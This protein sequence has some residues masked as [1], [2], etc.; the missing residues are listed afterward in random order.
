VIDSIDGV[1]NW[2]AA[3]VGDLKNCHEPTIIFGL[4]TENN[5]HD[6]TRDIT[7]TLQLSFPKE[8]SGQAVVIHLSAM[9]AFNEASFPKVLKQLL[10][11]PRLVPVG[12][13]LWYDTK[14]LADLGIRVKKFIDLSMLGKEHFRSFPGGYSLKALVERYLHLWVVKTNQDS[15]WKIHPL[16]KNLAE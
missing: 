2:A 13:Q 3:V 5:M 4:D 16:P 8:I 1:N 6:G 12:V 11:L 9:G 7:R 15:D 14:R 10:E